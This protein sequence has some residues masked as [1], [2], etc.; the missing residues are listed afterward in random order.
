M[1]IFFSKIVSRSSSLGQK[2][3]LTR[4]SRFLDVR[5]SRSYMHESEYRYDTPADKKTGSMPIF[6][7][8]FEYPLTSLETILI[9]TRIRMRMRISV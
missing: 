3:K 4:R 7:P 9:I 5:T 8:I 2:V 1:C 6:S